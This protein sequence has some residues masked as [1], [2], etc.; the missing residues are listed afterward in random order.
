MLLS[1]WS[2]D[3]RCALRPDRG[4]VKK[5]WKKTGQWASEPQIG[6]WVAQG[7]RLGESIGSEWKMIDL[8]GTLERSL[9]FHSFQSIKVCGIASEVFVLENWWR[10]LC[11]NLTPLDLA[12]CHSLFF[13]TEPIPL[14]CLFISAWK[15][16]SIFSPTQSFWYLQTVSL[17]NSS[18]TNCAGI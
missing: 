6:C 11:F 16:K 3:K 5:K 1:L 15:K 13:Y 2:K 9:S 7:V 14:W 4:M 8:S 18:C 12:S 10:H 17:C